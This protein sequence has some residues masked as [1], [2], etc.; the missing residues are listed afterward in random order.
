MSHIGKVQRC[1]ICGEFTGKH[2]VGASWNG[3]SAHGIIGLTWTPRRSWPIS[4]LR[5]SQI[6]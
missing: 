5:P 2:L 4:P 3:M 6:K 1:V